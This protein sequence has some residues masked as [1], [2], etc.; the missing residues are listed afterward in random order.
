MKNDE[1]LKKAF[2]KAAN[3]GWKEIFW[4]NWVQNA[5]D[6]YSDTDEHLMWIFKCDFL[7]AF[8]GE[9]E[10]N[11]LWWDEIEV[12]KNFWR[13]D[14]CGLPGFEGKRWQYHAQQM[15]LEKEP[16]KYLEKFL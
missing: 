11:S 5:W 13:N 3:N 6:D 2:E 7:K 9:E 16:L 1:I 14:C 10:P 4:K 12:L 15:V 8:F